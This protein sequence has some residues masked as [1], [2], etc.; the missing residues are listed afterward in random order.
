MPLEGQKFVSEEARKR[1]GLWLR[2]T[3]KAKGLSVKELAGLIGV[4]ENYIGRVESGLRSMARHTDLLNQLAKALDIDAREV[5]RQAQPTAP[6]LNYEETLASIESMA[7][8]LTTAKAEKP[9]EAEQRRAR[10]YRMVGRAIL[11]IVRGGKTP[12]R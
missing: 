12:E 3:R 2:T 6:D 9:T 1:F 7:S 4:S 5:W 10:R 11:D 8:A